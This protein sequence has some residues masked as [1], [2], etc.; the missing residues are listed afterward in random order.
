MEEENEEKLKVFTFNAEDLVKKYKEKMEK[1]YHVDYS[2][3]TVEATCLHCG[4]YTERLSTKAKN[5][6]EAL[7]KVISGEGFCDKCFLE[8]SASVYNRW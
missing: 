2:N 7:D 6:K 4:N 8:I 1:N 3:G 5:K